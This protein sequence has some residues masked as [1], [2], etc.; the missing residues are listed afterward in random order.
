MTPSSNLRSSSSNESSSIANPAKIGL[1]IECPKGT[2]VI[3]RTT[4]EDLIRAKYHFR[5]HL[6]DDADPGS[7]YSTSSYGYDVS[8]LT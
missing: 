7:G 8:N 2:V 1:E 5:R 6:L 3:Q 4:K